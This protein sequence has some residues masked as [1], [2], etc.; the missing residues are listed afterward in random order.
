M[1]Y[2]TTINVKWN[3]KLRELQTVVKSHI[4]Q[5]NNAQPLP[6]PPPKELKSPSESIVSKTD[7]SHTV[8]SM[9]VSN[10]SGGDSS[11][12]SSSSKRKA[13]DP[14]ESPVAQDKMKKMRKE[15]ELADVGLLNAGAAGKHIPIITCGDVQ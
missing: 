8:N 14:I 7:N 6:P 12:S 4:D 15:E 9:K 1:Q 13:P 10:I 5:L 3:K 2:A 11:S